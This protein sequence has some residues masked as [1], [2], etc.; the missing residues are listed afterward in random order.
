MKDRLSESWLEGTTV[1]LILGQTLI[2]T[3]QNVASRAAKRETEILKGTIRSYGPREV[4]LTP[5]RQP[6]ISLS[7]SRSS[8]ETQDVAM[9]FNSDGV[10][11]AMQPLL[12][13]C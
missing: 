12:Y 1:F 13:Q 6:R 11:W 7:E 4:S 2:P 8:T 5:R 3:M 9:R 10:C